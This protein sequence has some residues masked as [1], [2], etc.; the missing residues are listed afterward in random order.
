MLRPLS[1]VTQLL[2]VEEVILTYPGLV[3][4]LTESAIG[5]YREGVPFLPRIMSE[6]SRG[7]TGIDIH[8]GARIGEEV[9]SFID[10][11]TG[12]V[13]GETTDIEVK[14]KVYQGV[15]LEALSVE[16]IS[17][18]KR[19]PTIKNHVVL[20]AGATVLGGNTVIGDGAIVG[21]N[22]W[23][24]ASVEAQTTVLE[25]A[26][27]SIIELSQAMTIRVMPHEVHHRIGHCVLGLILIY[28]MS[29]SARSRC[30]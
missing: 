2:D 19:H 8:P 21:G 28:A 30:R 5:Y 15:T 10:H 13:I 14:V 26:H 25:T 4:Q 9:F 11:G 6:Y 1:S 7:Q 23:L 16:K 29:S 12:V 24:T 27:N 22:V 18:A 17:G 20:Y 3:S